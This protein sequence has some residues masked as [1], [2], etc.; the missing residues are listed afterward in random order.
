MKSAIGLLLLAATAAAIADARPASQPIPISPR[1]AGPGIT[2]CEDSSSIC[3]IE[4]EIRKNM[5]PDSAKFP[6]EPYVS[7]GS[8]VV[9]EGVKPWIMWTIRDPKDGHTYAFT[10]PA[11]ALGDEYV[12]IGLR[13]FPSRLDLDGGVAANGG[14][15]FKWQAKN[16]RFFA[17]R[18]FINVMQDEKLF[19]K[20]S[21][22]IIVNM[23]GA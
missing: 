4:V 17:T 3:S 22:P 6:C 7:A 10:T 1:G 2:H 21:D 20:E 9:K 12:G 15:A 16:R 18:Y 14:T 19:C 8:I 11:Q 23:G 13:D 5:G